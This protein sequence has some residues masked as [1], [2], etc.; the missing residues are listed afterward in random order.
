M[1]KKHGRLGA[2]ILMLCSG[3]SSA[4]VSEDAAAQLGTTLMPLGGERAGN[5]AGTIPPWQGGLT[6]TPP[7][8]SAGQHH[9]DP[10]PDDKPLFTITADNLNQY[11]DQLSAG[12][13]ALFAT[14]PQSYQIPVYPSRRTGAAPQWVYDN[15]RYNA[16]HARLENNGNSF[17]NAKGGIPFPVTDNAVEMLWNH[18]ARYRGVYGLRH[19]SEAVVQRNG[20]YSLVAA[21]QEILFKFYENQGAIEPENN[22]LFY[23]LSFVKSP[24]RLAGGAALVYESLDQVKEDRQ[25]W[26]YNSGQRRVRKAP[27]LS[28]DAPIAA[29]EGIRTADSTDMFNGLPDRFDWQVI[30]KQELYIPYNNYQLTHPSVSYSELLQPG[31]VN[32]AVTRNELHRVWVIEGTLREGARHAYSKRRFYL[33]EDSWQIVLADDYD[34]R[35]ALWKVSIAYLKNYYEVPTTW[36]ALDVYHD[37]QGRRYHVQNLDN[38]ER[39]TISFNHHIPS[40][41]YFKP[42]A[43]RQRSI[44]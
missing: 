41:N 1:L 11:Q 18:I 33:D 44:R 28:Y 29:S 36:T 13:R 2:F 30:G 8:Y 16:R 35:G 20:A 22:I 27:N 21:Q 5:V 12:Q 24:A 23:Y 26:V 37:L 9:I 43:L 15:T 25:A 17:A 19:A 7:G 4:A 42:A 40:D 32:P 39:E 31:H 34:S 14:Y 6:E 10:F 38:E 3:Y